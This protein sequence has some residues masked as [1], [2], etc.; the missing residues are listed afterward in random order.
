MSR[1]KS[2]GR[3][4]NGDSGV[5]AVAEYEPGRDW[6]ELYASQEVETM[7]WFSP[8]LD[9]DV[10]KALRRYNISGGRAL[11]VGSGPGTQAIELAR[12]GFDVTAVDVSESAMRKGAM[13]AA[14]ARVKAVF[15]QD[16]ILASRLGERFNLILDRGCFHTFQPQQRPIY[17]RQVRQLL[18]PDGLLLLKT[19]SHREP[20]DWGPYRF[21][22]NEIRGYFSADFEI[23]ALEETVYEG[24]NEMP[25]QALFCV[26]KL[27]QDG[28]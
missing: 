20:G 1:N 2:N 7:P 11:D 21:H 18:L 22:P 12:R 6:E 25:P 23:V 17:V 15:R 16:N 24:T 10:A 8:T 3:S 9:R 14:E 28:K 5:S 13:R 4:G 26:M 27:R 19:F